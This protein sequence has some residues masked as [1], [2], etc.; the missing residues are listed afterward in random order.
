MFRIRFYHTITGKE[1]PGIFFS[2]EKDGITHYYQRVGKDMF[3]E[4]DPHNYPDY[5]VELYKEMK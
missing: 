1:L 4:I 3:V 5:N 2:A